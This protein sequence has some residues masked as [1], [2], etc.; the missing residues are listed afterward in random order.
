[1]VRLAQAQRE[2]HVSRN[3]LG[4]HLALHRFRAVQRDVHAGVDHGDA[5]GL[6][7]AAV[8]IAE[9]LAE[10]GEVHVAAAHA[11]VLGRIHETHVAPVGERLAGLE[12]ILARLVELAD[13]GLRQHAAQQAQHAGAH[14][15]LLLA[16]A[17]GHVRVAHAIKS[18]MSGLTSAAKRSNC[19]PRRS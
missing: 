9:R 15:P 7:D 12:G 6:R 5:V 1:M 13:L 4:Q 10:H 16:E 18:S 3:D 8:V 11:A 17:E 14:L 19:S 2:A